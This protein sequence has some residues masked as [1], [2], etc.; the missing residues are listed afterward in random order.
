MGVIVFFFSIL[1]PPLYD[2]MIIMTIEISVSEKHDNNKL[3]IT[4]MVY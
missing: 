3:R 1:Y 4:R 2:N